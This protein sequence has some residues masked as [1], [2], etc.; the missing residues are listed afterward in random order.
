MLKQQEK[1]YRLHVRKRAGSLFEV[2]QRTRKFIMALNT[3]NKKH[4]LGQ[5]P[6][7]KYPKLR[8]VPKES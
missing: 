7:L 3:A 6:P 8:E 5:Q 4:A 2:A 1:E